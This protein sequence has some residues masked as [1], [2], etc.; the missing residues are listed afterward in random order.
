MNKKTKF[1]KKAKLIADGG[2]YKIEKIDK[3]VTRI[4]MIVARRIRISEPSLDYDG[5]WHFD[6][7]FVFDGIKNG[8]AEYRQVH[9]IRIDEA[10]I[11]S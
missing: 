9:S 11:K 6:L 4:N 5:T 8:Y 2:F 3:F 1:P 10:N 7:E